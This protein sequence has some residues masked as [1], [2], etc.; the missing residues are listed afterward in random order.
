MVA[1]RWQPVML[2]DRLTTIRR[3]ERSGRRGLLAA[4]VLV[5]AASLAGCLTAEQQ[6]AL[7][8]LNSDRQAYNRRV[9]PANLQAAQTKAQSWAEHLARQ[10]SLSHSVLS[11]GMSG[12][13]WCGLAENVAYGSSIAAV[14][15]QFMASSG[16]RANVL[17]TSWDV[18]GVGYARSGSRHYVVQFF[19][20][21]C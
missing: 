1:C 12:V 6:T 8:E 15:N 4:A 14:Q 2:R 13:S 10:G 9:L 11:Q 5:V 3:H 21:L 17:N 16:H 18:V 19:V 20:N 7:D